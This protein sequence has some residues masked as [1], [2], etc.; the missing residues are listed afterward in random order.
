V[1]PK[2]CLGDLIGSL[3]QAREHEVKRALGYAL[4]WSEL[5]RM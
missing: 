2:D 4:G 5:K 3:P 1:V